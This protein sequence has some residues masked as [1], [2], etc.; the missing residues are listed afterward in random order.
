[1][2]IISFLST[3]PTGPTPAELELKNMF[4]PKLQSQI[5]RNPT[6]VTPENFL[7]RQRVSNMPYPIQKDPRLYLPGKYPKRNQSICPQS[8]SLYIVIFSLFF[9]S[10]SFLR[11]RQSLSLFFVLSLHFLHS[12][13]FSRSL[14]L[15]TVVV[16]PHMSATF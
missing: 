6:T 8:F 9:H 2:V 14:S 5:Y 15:S 16:Y 7:L 12:L 1:M 4:C 10:T 11:F 13:F 3:N